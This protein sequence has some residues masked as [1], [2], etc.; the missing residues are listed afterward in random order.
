MLRAILFDFNG[1]LVDDEPL[2]LELF[3]RVLGEEGIELSV[4]DYRTRYLG[5]DDSSCFADLLAR[6]GRP[7]TPDRLSRLIARKSAYYH[8]RI[9]AD[10]FPIFP[11]AAELIADAV[12]AELMLGVVSG[13]LRDEVEGALDQIGVR[14]HFKCLVCAEDVDRGKP[15]PEG[16]RRGLE[17]L[18]ALP[19]LPSRLVHPHEVLA[20]EDTPAGLQAAAAASLSTLAVAHTYP[21]SELEPADQVVPSLG[22]LDLRE[23]QKLFADRL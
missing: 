12:D 14:A 19:P 22:E 6:A 23:L 8:Q 1:V 21:E 7:A 17:Q 2:H 4:D 15:D 9:R 5:H 13:A 16:Y 18:N 10:G 20:I 3:Q 11:G